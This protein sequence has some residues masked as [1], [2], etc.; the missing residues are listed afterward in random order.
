MLGKIKDLTDG[1]KG[2]AVVIVV[3]MGVGAYFRLTYLTTVSPHVDEY[4]TVWAAQKIMEHGYPLLPSGFIYLPGVLFSYLDALFIYLFGSS[5]GVARLP[6]LLI[7]L[8]SVPLIYL[9]GKRMFSRGV[10]L[11]AAALLAFSPEAIVW[12][13]RARM[14]ALQQLAVILALCYFYEGFIGG[15]DDRPRYLFALFF[16]AALFS[17][18]TTVLLFLPL[19]LAILVRRGW[20]WFFKPGVLGPL[21][22]SG[23]GA[24][25]TFA[26]GLIAGPLTSAGERPF[27]ELSLGWGLKSGFFFR[28][29]FWLWPY[30]PLTLLFLL[31]FV[32]LL[33]PLLPSSSKQLSK[34]VADFQG[35]NA[36]LIFCYVTFCGVM[37]EVFLLVGETWRRPRYLFLLLPVYF[38]LAAGTLARGLAWI[39]Q[40]LRRWK[41]WERREELRLA[42]WLLIALIAGGYTLPAAMAAATQPEPAYDRAFGYVEEHWQE[43]DILVMI[44]PAIGCVYLGD[45][46]YYANQVT[47]REHLMIVDGAPVDNWTGST[48]VN[49]VGQLMP[50]LAEN[51][52]V[53][54]VVDEGRFHQQYYPDFIRFVRQEMEAVYERQGVI[55]FLAQDFSSPP[56]H[57]SRRANL[58]DKIEFLGYQLDAVEARPGGVVPFSLFWQAWQPLTENYSIFVRLADKGDAFTWQEDGQSVNGLFPT[59]Q[60][61]TGVEVWDGREI[62]IPTD[63]PPGRYRLEVG[64]YEPSTLERLPVLDEEGR[65]QGDTLVLDYLKVMGDEESLSPQ[66]S[67]AATFGDSISLLGYDLDPAA[68]KPGDVIRLKLYWQAREP[69]GEDYTVFV[70]VVGEDGRLWGQH[71]GQPEGGFYPTCFWD[72]GEV[73]VDEHEIVLRPDTPPG[74]YQIVTGL[75][76]LANGERLALDTGDQGVSDSHLLLGTVQVSE[77]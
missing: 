22:L 13:G 23:A 46:D 72:E 69:V 52:R 1:R 37:A 62:A 64:W 7:G 74:E 42:A 44:L 49:S 67:L 63:A 35:Q 18:T 8:F 68:T 40:H 34:R 25:T 73:I 70:H 54:L 11:L 47:Y 66:H 24:L 48:L 15:D 19:L 27:L 4:L 71:D 14:Y 57:R 39:G 2:I 59:S 60:W 9:L 65:P 32:Y 16:I 12:S 30:L 29:F 10:G 53:W 6:S 17:Q 36:A 77:P 20:R 21:F 58:A 31:G 41:T 75:Y 56:I 26:L 61:P 28:E 76:R 50:V 43:G 38:L 51:R 33:L 55:A 5:E 3:L 45:C